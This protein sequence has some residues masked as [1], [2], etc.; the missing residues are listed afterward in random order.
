M[1]ETYSSGK[2]ESCAVSCSV[3]GQTNFDSILGELVA[4]GGSNDAVSL[5]PGVGDLA[6][7][8]LVGDAHD[9]SVLRRV[10]LVLGL[11]NQTLAGVVVGLALATPAE[12][13]L[14]PLEV[15]LALDYLDERLKWKRIKVKNL[16]QNPPDQTMNTY[17]L[18]KAAPQF[19]KLYV[20][21]LKPNSLSPYKSKLINT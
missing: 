11:N 13:D 14:E 5:Q 3:V 4:V 10:V 17:V 18:G 2:K 16:K 19:S 20:K 9:H 8:V 12:L 1:I 21:I 6:T 15:G 7:D